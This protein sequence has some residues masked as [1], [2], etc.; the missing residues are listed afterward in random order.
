MPKAKFELKPWSED[1]GPIKPCQAA[2][3]S[4]IAP[5]VV[6][7][8]TL[9]LLT[10]ESVSF[11]DSMET[12]DSNGL[13]DVVPEILIYVSTWVCCVFLCCDVLFA[14]RICL[15]VC[16]CAHCLPVQMNG[17]NPQMEEVAQRYIVKHPGKIKLMG[18]G[19]NRGIAR[20]M[21][22]MTQAAKGPYFLFMERDFQVRFA[23]L[24]LRATAAFASS[25]YAHLHRTTSACRSSSSLERASR[26]N[27]PRGSIYSQ[28]ALVRRLVKCLL[29]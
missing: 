7:G 11:A 24:G 27:Y 15:C 14:I 13:F 5:K 26:S 1:R 3:A 9:G 23:G 4:G 12:Y 17:R 21:V 28:M 6:D 8:V 22:A 2:H 18:D 10:H 16:F 29:C 19:Q 25:A 20:A